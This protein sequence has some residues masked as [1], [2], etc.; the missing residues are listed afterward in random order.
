MELFEGK[1]DEI[2]GLLV[3]V[4]W[5]IIKKSKEQY[6][7]AG[8]ALYATK[9]L[10]VEGVTDFKY[11]VIIKREE[12]YD[13]YSLD[14][15]TYANK[16][17]FTIFIDPEIEPL[18]YADVNNDLQMTVRHEIEHILQEKKVPNKMPFPS[19]YMLTKINKD[20]MKYFMADHEIEAMVAGF[21]RM[22]KTQKEKIDVVIQNYLNYFVGDGSIT[23]RQAK[24]VK[25]KWLEFAKT[26]YPAAQYRYKRK[27][28]EDMEKIEE[29]N[30]N[31]YDKIG[32][33]MAKRAKVPM[34]FKKKKSKKN[35]NAMAQK[36]FEHQILSFDDF[37]SAILET[38]DAKQESEFTAEQKKKIRE[39][40]KN[41]KGDFEDNDV[42]NFADKLGLNKHEVEEYIDS[43]SR[44]HL[45]ESAGSNK[46]GFH[47]N[48]EKD[49]LQ[50]DSFRK[51]IYTGKSMQLVLMTLKPGEE[52]GE[53][54][55]SNIDQFFRFEAG[56]GK[57]KINDAEYDVSDGDSVII[58]QGSKHNII[59]TGK[60]ALQL[61]TIYTPPKHQDQIEFATKAE[62]EKSKEKFNGKTTE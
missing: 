37:R 28:N 12:G 9:P 46:R 45:Q 23:T 32:T 15:N 36:K 3:D 60:S 31:P 57:V 2:T 44:T 61:Y 56:K 39:F 27:I 6:D 40:I 52:I 25:D 55:H 30:I 53:E 5:F 42:H 10:D 7:Q 17:I 62:A 38:G 50:N 26:R 8:I 35:Q 54:V 59:N 16:I 4:I 47:T 41:Y 20:P 13:S 29:E 21:Y 11:Q 24:M 49:T 22:A 14:A 43:I 33:M 18:I 58:P 48:I 19:R 34:T 1:Y 51:V